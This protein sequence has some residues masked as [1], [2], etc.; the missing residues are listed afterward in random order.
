MDTKGFFIFDARVFEDQVIL[1]LSTCRTQLNRAEEV[2]F[3]SVHDDHQLTHQ[4]VGKNCRAM[5]NFVFD[6]GLIRS[7]TAAAPTTL[8]G[9]GR[10][11]APELATVGCSYDCFFGH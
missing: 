7:T 6:F 10:S 8:R 9:P 11:P 2:K 1:L 5:N 4:L 3:V